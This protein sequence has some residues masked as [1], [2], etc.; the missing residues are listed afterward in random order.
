VEKAGL[1]VNALTSS[2]NTCL[3]IA[4]KNG[5]IGICKY[6]V[7]EAKPLK[8]DVL[9]KGLDND[10]PCEAALEMGKVAEGN[11]LLYHQKRMQHWRN[12]SCLLKFYLHKH[13]TKVFK[14]ISEGILKE[15]I[16]YA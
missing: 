10:T 2:N 8:A 14:G 3:H 4:A 5:Y 16:K 1:N 7:E 6:L 9:I 13:N 12:R 15:I 11:Y